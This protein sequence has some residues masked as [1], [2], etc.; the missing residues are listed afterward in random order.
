MRDLSECM[1]ESTIHLNVIQAPVT[2][3]TLD[4]AY[5]SPNSQRAKLKTL[6]AKL[7]QALNPTVKSRLYTRGILNF[8]AT[9]A[10]ATWMKSHNLQDRLDELAWYSR[11]GIPTL[12]KKMKTN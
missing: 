2:S 10:S 4:A 12:G 6:N 11:G 7:K 3:W 5:Y 9:P 1:P 8:S